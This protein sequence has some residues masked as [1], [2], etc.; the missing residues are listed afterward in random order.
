M[1]TDESLSFS[2]LIERERFEDFNE[3]SLVV[4]DFFPDVDL[5]LFVKD[6]EC[7]FRSF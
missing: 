6:F 2:D 7:F 5:R 3:C 1:V 4:E